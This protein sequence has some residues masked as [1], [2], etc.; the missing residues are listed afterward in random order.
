MKDLEKYL[1]RETWPG[2]RHGLT[3][4][5]AVEMLEICRKKTAGMDKEKAFGTAVLDA[6]TAGYA[7]GFE[8]GRR[9]EKAK[10]RAK[11]AKAKG[12]MPG[13]TSH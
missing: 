1:D 7:A 3:A 8:A 9:A 12:G 11:K 5:D 2:S 13:E 4:T 10:A 6:L